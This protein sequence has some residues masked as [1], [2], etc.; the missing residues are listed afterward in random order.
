MSEANRPLIRSQQHG[1]PRA[2]AADTTRAQV[3][4][5]EHQ[6]NDGR[7]SSPNQDQDSIFEYDYNRDD[8]EVD[9]EESG[10]GRPTLFVWVLALV[11]GISGLLF[12]YE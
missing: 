7:S 8:V 6:V 10:L 3:S 2:P 4:T 9:M 1:S 11:A 5:V 12:G